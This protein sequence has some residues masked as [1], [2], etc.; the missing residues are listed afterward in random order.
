MIN[1]TII[2]K[3]IYS[4]YYGGDGIG[5]CVGG[6]DIGGIGQARVQ[7]LPHRNPK[8]PNHFGKESRH[9]F[10]VSGHA[11]AAKDSDTDE[12]KPKNPK[13][14]RNRTRGR[15]STP[16][17]YSGGIG[18][19]SDQSIPGGELPSSSVTP[20]ILGGSSNP[21]NPAFSSLSTLLP[22]PLPPKSSKKRGNEVRELERSEQVCLQAEHFKA[23]LQ[24]PSTKLELSKVL[25][26]KEKIQQR[27]TD[28]F[29]SSYMDAV[30]TQ[31]P[32]CRAA[33][34]WDN[35]KDSSRLA[36]LAC[37]FIEAL[38]D[39]EATPDTLSS[40]AR[41]LE[42]QASIKL[43]RS[44]TSAICRR[45]A[46]ELMQAGD[47]DKVIAFL[48]PAAKRDFPNG[49][50]AVMPAEDP[51]NPSTPAS[52]PDDV[53]EFQVT[54][55]VACLTQLCMTPIP[56]VPKDGTE[57]EKLGQ[58]KR[59][60]VLNGTI[61]KL[62]DFF[63]V[64]QSS[65]LC[66]QFSEAK[67]FIVDEMAKLASLVT[68]ALNTAPAFMEAAAC[69]QLE[70]TRT[71]LLKAKAG[72]FYTAIAM[73]P[74]GGEVSAR[75]SQRV[76][77]NRADVILSMDLDSAFEIAQGL[78]SL[79]PESLLKTKDGE[80]EVVV[81]HQHK[82]VDMVSKFVCF[83]E[84]ASKDLQNRSVDPLTFIEGKIMALSS[85][86]EML[87]TQRYTSKFNECMSPLMAAMMKGALGEDSHKLYDV[88]VSMATYLPLGKLPLSKILG[89]ASA[90]A[91]ERRLAVVTTYMG[92]LKN[93]FALIVKMLTK[94]FNEDLL[95]QPAVTEFY[96]KLQDKEARSLLATTAPFLETS[97]KSML[98]AMQ[99]CLTTWLGQV[100]STFVKFLNKLAEPDVIVDT[101]R[102]TLR[103]D[104]LGAFDVK[105]VNTEEAEL[106]WFFAFSNYIKYMG[107]QQVLLPGEGVE[108]KHV[109]AAYICVAGALLRI[110]K[111]VMVIL[112]QEKVCHDDKVLLFKEMLHAS[113]SAAKGSSPEWETKMS[114]LIGCQHVFEKLAQV[115]GQ[116]DD[117]FEQAC[118]IT[119]GMDSVT[120]FYKALQKIAAAA[121]SEF[122]AAIGADVASLQDA[123]NTLYKD[124]IAKNDLDK[125]FKSDVLDKQSMLALCTDPNMQGLVLSCAKADRFLLE[126]GGM[127]PRRKNLKVPQWM[128]ESS[129]KLI[130]ALQDDV[131]K[132]QAMDGSVDKDKQACKVSMATVRYVNGSMTLGQ[133]LSRDLQPGETRIGLVGRC[134][135]ILAKKGIAVE[136]MLLKKVSAMKGGK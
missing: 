66:S 120:A 5:V 25:K 91:L 92:L 79:N 117:M 65:S 2:Y 15:D 88:V 89:K 37:D 13:S 135:N 1:Y 83:K 48:D 134:Q 112:S 77:Q 124:L 85:S 49:I 81:P 21:T 23:A 69:E 114:R 54:C 97:F 105:A 78:K 27:L 100:G 4:R 132:F 73:S 82:I 129:A 52:V 115:T 26:P 28:E 57:D 70:A 58:K 59:Q 93:G 103:E 44:I 113:R 17:T 74:I 101:V 47:F 96:I 20:N 90:E 127:L 130:S 38:A 3:V 123:V 56:P 63:K 67:H 119:G 108:S 22:L 61:G 34:V 86:L 55:L 42:E 40:R 33:R 29:T 102:A 72:V 35:L 131:Q 8:P 110:A 98:D 71:G 36:E 104:V 18:G 41:S 53:R 118:S 14:K 87:I 122:V 109:H 116:F 10:R 94:D 39:Q 6:V 11:K 125:I 51:S 9:R 121:A 75:V 80:V 31:G 7:I 30:R 95:S 68:A 24:D 136:P 50:A 45:S 133:A 60:E 111:Y 107:T 128:S 46:E 32:E 62:N 126:V 84:K 16:T 76:Q 19:T 99:A 106:D 64:W 12:D 43:P